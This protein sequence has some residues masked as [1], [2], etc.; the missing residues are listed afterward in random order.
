[1]GDKSVMFPRY[2]LKGCVRINARNIS[3]SLLKKG[4]L[5]LLRTAVYCLFTT[6]IHLCYFLVPECIGQKL[7]KGMHSRTFES[8]GRYGQ[9]R[10][11]LQTDVSPVFFKPSRSESI[12]YYFPCFPFFLW[13][14]LRER[15][16]P[17][18]TAA[19]NKFYMLEIR[20]PLFSTFTPIRLGMINTAILFQCILFH[21]F[22]GE[23]NK[24]ALFQSQLIR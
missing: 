18:L 11:L 5:L 4:E 13:K 19:T 14:I 17:L 15:A 21:H 10:I 24:K 7:S 3:F 1:M 20:R 8:K 23:G 2:L 9:R 12:C 6:L 16:R 22:S